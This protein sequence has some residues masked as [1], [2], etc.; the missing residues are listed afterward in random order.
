[1]LCPLPSWVSGMGASSG[2]H[3]ME[4]VVPIVAQPLPGPGHQIPEC[5]KIRA[6]VGPRL[7]FILSHLRPSV[8]TES[9]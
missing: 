6:I 2:I 9:H 4:G 8:W 1:M 3:P 5:F 7:Q